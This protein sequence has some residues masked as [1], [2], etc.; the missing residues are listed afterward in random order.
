MGGAGGGWNRRFGIVA[1]VLL[2]LGLVVVFRAAVRGVPF[3][4]ALPVAVEGLAFGDGLLAE[5]VRLGRGLAV[6]F[7]VVF[8]FGLVINGGFFG[9]IKD[10]KRLG[11][12]SNGQGRLC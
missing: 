2:L 10:A 9:G 11:L 12:R 5:P 6:V 3:L 4:A 7:M 1:A 8:R